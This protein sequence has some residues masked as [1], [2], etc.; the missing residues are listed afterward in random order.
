MVQ[1]EHEVRDAARACPSPTAA[2]NEVL[3]ETPMSE[4]ARRERQLEISK[5][6]H[7]SVS[8]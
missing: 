1:M 5:A 4:E 2:V 6:L 7:H 3:V 8:L